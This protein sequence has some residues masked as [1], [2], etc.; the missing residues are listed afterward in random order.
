[1]YENPGRVNARYP[2]PPPPA[3]AHVYSVDSFHFTLL[4][5]RENAF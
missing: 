3:D 4:N 1:M 5:K 2:P